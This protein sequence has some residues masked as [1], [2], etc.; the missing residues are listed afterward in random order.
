M[1]TAVPSGRPASTGG[2]TIDARM[3][4]R[5]LLERPDSGFF[6]SR[7]TTVTN[8]RYGQQTSSRRPIGA[9]ASFQLSVAFIA[10][11][12][13]FLGSSFD[14]D[15]IRTTGVQYDLLALT[16]I[17]ALQGDLMGLIH[18]AGGYSLGEG[19]VEYLT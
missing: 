17:E 5:S 10:A 12:V 18:N 7:G 15:E 4:P 11:D 19:A 13:V 16:S 8:A 3:I 14:A 6:R 1:R 2:G 9:S